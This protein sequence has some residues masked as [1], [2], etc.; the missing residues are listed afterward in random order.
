MSII[1]YIGFYIHTKVISFCEK[2][3]DGEVVDQRLI[4]AT[5]DSLTTVVASREAPL[6]YSL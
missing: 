6:F 5:R 2:K 1:H 4:S 3:V